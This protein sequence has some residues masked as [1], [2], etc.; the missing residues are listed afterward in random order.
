[1]TDR[2]VGFIVSLEKPIRDDDAEGIQE[3]IKMI[4]GVVS[5]KPV[6]AD[7]E[8]FIAR[9]QVKANIKERLYLALETD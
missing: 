3:A 6:V 5:I 1:M 9:E 7:A 4:K 8:Y 2:Y